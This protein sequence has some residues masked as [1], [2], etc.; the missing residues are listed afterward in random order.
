M[1]NPGMKTGPA[2]QRLILWIAILASF[3]SFLDSS[4]INVALPAMDRELGGGLATQQWVV[5]AYLITLGALILLAGSLSDV[6]GRILILRIG[7]IGFG[8]TSLVC[9]FAPTAEVLILGRGFQGAAAALLVPS[10]LALIT[11]NFSGPERAKAIGQWTAGTTVAFI[12]GPVL[13]GLLVDTVGWRAVFWINVVP[14]A[15]TLYLLAV[16]GMKDVR[17]HGIRI[18]YAGAVLCVLGLGG[19]VYALIEQGNQ[20]WGSPSIWAPFGLGLLCLAGFLWRQATARQ[21]LMPLSLF[22]V[23][24]FGVGNIATTFIYAG[25]SIGG[26]I[27]VLFLQQVAGF[28]ATAAALATLPISILNIT[29]SS[30]FGALSGRFGPRWFMALGPLMG[31][32]G[33][34]LMV[35]SRLPVD[36]WTQ[37]LPGILLFGLGL[38]VTVAPLT[39]AILGSV[40]E[41]QSGI[42]SAVNNAVARV[43]GL[44]GIAVLGLVTGPVF[45]LQGFH[46]AL[47]ATAVLLA[48][49]GVVSGIGIQN[50][51]KPAAPSTR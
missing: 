45:D 22:A 1:E 15:V 27:V 48:V 39:A 41:E 4:V 46:Q 25:L 38:S 18:D 32:A 40:S 47:I 23:R 31:A 26:L 50:P 24:N 12:A 44:V 42:G 6:L 16:L 13:G 10:S 20:G 3:V 34:L 37:L 8:V 28:P 5:D 14:I 35:T 17:A 33:Y 19:P 21:P 49:G 30:W 36:Y 7:L 43:A 9:A 29:L 51:G 11:A 2:A